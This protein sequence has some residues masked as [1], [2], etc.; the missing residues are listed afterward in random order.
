MEQ[1]P[2]FVVQGESGE[3]KANL[4]LLQFL[5]DQLVLLL[6]LSYDSNM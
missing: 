2:G 4:A 1:Q 5:I 3:V 6:K